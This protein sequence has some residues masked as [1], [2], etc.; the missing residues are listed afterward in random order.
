MKKLRRYLLCLMLSCWAAAGLLPGFRSL[1][2][3][4]AYTCEEN[5][6]KDVGETN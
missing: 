5:P 1:A 6:L 4:P 2:N 3:Q